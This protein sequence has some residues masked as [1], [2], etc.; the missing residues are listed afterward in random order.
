MAAGRLGQFEFDERALNVGSG[1]LGGLQAFDFF[2]SRS[3]LGRTS[4]G[5]KA[6]NE[7]LQLGDFLFAHL[8][9]GFDARADGG[10]GED[11]VVVA[12]NVGDNGFV[13]DVGNVGADFIEEMAVVRNDDENAFVG[14]QVILEPMDGIE[15]EIVGGLIEKERGRVAE[16]GLGEKD[17][18]FLAAV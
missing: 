18:N 4:A 6:R 2:L 14:G 15:V 13:V 16:K 3:G 5:G 7:I 8:V 10:L 11:H 9:F 1:E 12:A 17:A